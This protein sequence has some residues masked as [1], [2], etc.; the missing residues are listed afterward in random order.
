LYKIGGLQQDSVNFTT[1][2]VTGTP[3]YGLPGAG[4]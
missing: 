4:S 1:A 3:P 2:R